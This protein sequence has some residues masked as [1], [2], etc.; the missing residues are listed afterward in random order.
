MDVV[1]P[2]KKA[3]TSFYKQFKKLKTEPKTN[4]LE[5]F[6]RGSKAKTKNTNKQY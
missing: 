3:K 4:I 2:D 6:Y 5:N 1:R